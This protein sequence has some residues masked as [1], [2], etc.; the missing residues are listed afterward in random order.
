MEENM[1]YINEETLNCSQIVFC[2]ICKSQNKK[3]SCDMLSML[4]AINAGFGTGDICSALIGALCAMGL[5]IDEYEI[6]P[7]RL[8]FL[9]DFREK[10]GTVNCCELSSEKCSC[11]DII[12]FCINWVNSKINLN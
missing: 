11:D 4:N 3:V 6:K 12:D 1:V 7:L 8:I 5:F 2:A 9:L 10:F